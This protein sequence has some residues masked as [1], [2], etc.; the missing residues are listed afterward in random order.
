MKTTLDKFGRIVIPKEIRDDLGLTAGATLEIE[1]A[2][3]E[4]RLQPVRKEPLLVVKEGVTVYRGGATGDLSKAV[5]AHRRMRI[6]S[7]ADR[8]T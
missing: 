5:S 3:E 7:L 1:E 4:I 8:S 6:G 2:G